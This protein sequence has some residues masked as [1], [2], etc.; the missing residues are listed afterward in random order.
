MGR[1]FQTTFNY[2]GGYYPSLPLSGNRPLNAIIKGANAWIRPDLGFSESWM[3]MGSSLASMGVNMLVPLGSDSLPGGI[4]SGSILVYR[5]DSTWFIAAGGGSAYRNGSAIGTASSALQFLLS[6]VLFTAGLS[7]PAAPTLYLKAGSTDKCRGTFSGKLT[8]VRAATGEESNASL[9]SNV[10]TAKGQK[11]II[12]LNG[13]ATPADG[14]RWA[15]YGCDAGFSTIGDW[16]FRF[17]FDSSQLSTL[18]DDQGN[19]RP[20]SIEFDYYDFETTSIAAPFN[21][22]PPPAGTH[23]ATLGSVVVVLGSYGGAGVS[24]SMPGRLAWPAL[25]T[26]FLN[27][28]EPIIRVD[29]RPQNG[30]QA[31]FT[32][33]SV[34][35]ILLSGDDNGPVF[36]R[37]MWPT[38][39]ISNPSGACMVES[40]IWAVLGD[41]YLARS[42]G[43]QDPDTSFTDPVRSDVK[44]I[45]PATAVVGYYPKY[46]AVIFMDG[47]VAWP[48]MRGGYEGRKGWSTPFDLGGTAQ[49][50]ATVG[51]KLLV[52]IGGAIKTFDAGNG[53][54]INWSVVPAWQD[55]G[56]ILNRKAVWGWRTNAK[57]AIT[58][59][60]FGNDDLTTALET[61][62]DAG[63]G[64]RILPQVKTNVK[65]LENFTIGH[66]G[67]TG[68][69]RVH[70]TDVHGVYD[71]AY[72]DI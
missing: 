58:S 31:V 38:A 69:A 7:Q 8:Q 51:G 24:P 34:Q 15:Y 27:P 48:F 22:S 46:D 18:T 20:N 61:Q 30:W 62:T 29:G 47:A 6:S 50:A 36:V 10:V 37:S 72:V 3:G 26:R 14:K 43:H 53:S 55:M 65:K 35:A 63:T 25:F 5:G 70:S 32:K 2:S 66:R 12:S 59:E 56:S 19:S 33:H 1:R 68:G 60:L 39:G 41:G 23:L 71:G 44:N 67:T 42:S 11:L 4:S 40:E 49:A 57:G 54:G 13:I 17:E 28:A 64:E 21:F 9:A 52:N 45:N 16:Y